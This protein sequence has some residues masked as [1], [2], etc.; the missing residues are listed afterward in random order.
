MRLGMIGAIP[1]FPVIFYVVQEENL[2]LHNTKIFYT[3]VYS[4]ESEKFVFFEKVES[5]IEGTVASGITATPQARFS[6]EADSVYVT[7]RLVSLLRLSMSE[8]AHDGR[9]S[10]VFLSLTHIQLHKSSLCS[11]KKRM[12][13]VE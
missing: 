11:R 7:G 5:C 3:G 12:I 6:Y 4:G 9:Q 8:R 13:I 10:F 1:P 2:Y